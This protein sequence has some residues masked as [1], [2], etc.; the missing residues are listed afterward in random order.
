MATS[1]VDQHLAQGQNEG[2]AQ[3]FAAYIAAKAEP[4]PPPASA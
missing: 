3:P 1:E 2:R 4:Q